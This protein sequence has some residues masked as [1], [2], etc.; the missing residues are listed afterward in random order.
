MMSIV[1][2]IDRT[3]KYALGKEWD[4]LY[5][6]IDLHG[7]V[8]E[9]NYKDEGIERVFFPYAKEVLQL[10]TQRKDTRLIMFTSTTQEKIDEYTKLFIDNNIVFDYVNC[11]PEVENTRYA[12]FI[13]K[14]YFNVM[15]ED[16]AGFAPEDWILIKNYI[17][18]MPELK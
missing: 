12:S 5:W 7:T 15:L 10:L 1:E 6:A 3:Y 13:D 16:K 18:N 14:F 4:T 2:A 8:L 17:G 11:N 9:A